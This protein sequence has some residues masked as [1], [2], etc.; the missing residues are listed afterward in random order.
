MHRTDISSQVSF[1][2]IIPTHQRPQPLHNCLSAINRLD[3][4]KELF[5]VIVINDGGDLNQASMMDIFAGQMDVKFFSQPKAGPAA[6]RNTGASRA[7]NRYLV[8]TDD[9]C[10]PAVDWLLKFNNRLSSMSADAIAGRTINLLD[11]NPYSTAS[12]ILVDFLYQYYNS[13]TFRTGFFTSNNLLL[14]ADIFREIGG[15]DIHFPK[16]AAEDRDLC[17]RLLFHE[18]KVIFADEIIV[19]HAHSLNFPAFCR[20]HFNYGKGAYFYH[21]KYTARHGARVRLEPLP[22]Y[23]KLFLYQL[24]GTSPKFKFRI[25]LLL[26][27]SQIANA[28]GYFFRI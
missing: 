4:P 12:Q 28:A 5:E 10:M 22:F 1:S 11:K 27:V 23:S 18:K 15:F 2:I 19:F 13:N 21:K 7:R 3:Y 14:A 9:D 8:F 25:L 24:R 16:A 26:V 6:A 17:D 20:Q